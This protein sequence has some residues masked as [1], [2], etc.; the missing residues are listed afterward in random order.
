MFVQI[1]TKCGQFNIRR[2]ITA[3]ACF[4]CVPANFETCRCFCI[5]FDQSV[6]QCGKFCIRCVVATRACFVC[7]P[8]DFKTRGCFC[9]VLDQSMTKCGKF[10]ICRVITARACFVCVP[11]DFEARRCFCGMSHKVVSQ[12]LRCARL[13]TAADTTIAPFCAA[14]RTGWRSD[15]IPIPHRM[16]QCR[17]CRL[18][19]KLF[20]ATNANRQKISV[21]CTSGINGSRLRCSVHTST[22]IDACIV[23]TLPVFIPALRL[24]RRF[25]VN[26]LERLRRAEHFIPHR[27]NT[28]RNGNSRKFSTSI[29]CKN[30]QILHI[31]GNIDAR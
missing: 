16:S 18:A 6:S 27:Q 21:G 12:C 11:T 30:T 23:F 8:T 19:C 9:V 24:R 31:V 28:L 10:C 29:E 22:P 2:V 5:V 25:A 3:R 17:L 1:V 4:V 13:E 20:T 7:I 14:D 15:C 26:G